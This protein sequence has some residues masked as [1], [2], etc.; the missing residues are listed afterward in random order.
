MAGNGKL[1]QNVRNFLDRCVKIGQMMRNFLSHSKPLMPMLMGLCIGLA[2]SLIMTPFTHDGECEDSAHN[3]EFEPYA[4]NKD[5]GD[6]APAEDIFND[7]PKETMGSKDKVNLDY[8]ISDDFEPRRKEVKM[9]EPANSGRMVRV[10]PRYISTELGIRE[11]L[12]VGVL[13]TKESL[14]TLGVAVNKTLSQYVT[15]LVFFMYSKG[16]GLPSGIP[17]VLFTD[18]KKHLVPFYM[19]KYIGDHYVRAYDWFFFLRDDTYVRG[20]LL[21]DM[22]NHISVSKDLLM[23]RPQENEEGV[24]CDLGYGVLVSQVLS[25]YYV[26]YSHPIYIVDH[27]ISSIIER[28]NDESL[29]S[30]QYQTSVFC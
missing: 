28:Y 14:D 23:G 4:N 17:I 3:S 16:Q 27:F 15:K 25:S 29:S 24:I 13:T 6:L 7:Q 18:E 8:W 11:K 22:V 30:T 2:L 26:S 20:N 19:F 10:R 21:F 9:Q 5:N 12:F 1:C